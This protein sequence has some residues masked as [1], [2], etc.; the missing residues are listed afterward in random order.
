MK[1]LETHRWEYQE[2]SYVRKQTIMPPKKNKNTLADGDL[3]SPN[4]PET[5]SRR[6]F[7]RTGIFCPSTNRRRCVGSRSP[8]EVFMSNMTWRPCMG[9]DTYRRNDGWVRNQTC[10]WLFQF[11][12][13]LFFTWFCIWV[14][15]VSYNH[16]Q[17]EW[18]SFSPFYIVPRSVIQPHLWGR[19]PSPAAWYPSWSS[20]PASCRGPISYPAKVKQPASL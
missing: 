17:W 2:D 13:V 8:Q 11:H 18:F 14:I 9:L 10:M 12:G 15:W 7:H 6:S 1:M 4:G 3:L 20:Q 19:E 16:E 5:R